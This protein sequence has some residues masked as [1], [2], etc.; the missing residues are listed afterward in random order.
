M[1]GTAQTTPGMLATITAN[2]EGQRGRASRVSLGLV[3]SHWAD[4]GGSREIGDARPH[5][6]VLDDRP[7]H[8]WTDPGGRRPPPVFAPEKREVPSRRNHFFH[9]GRDPDSLHL[10]QAENSFP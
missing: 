5:H 8:R 6:P 2:L 3:R 10:L 4:L 7:R 9:A 1:S